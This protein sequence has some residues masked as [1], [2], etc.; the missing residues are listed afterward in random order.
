[1]TFLTKLIDEFGGSEKQRRSRPTK[2]VRSTCLTFEYRRTE[3]TDFFLLSLFFVICVQ[4]HG[5]FENYHG[6]DGGVMEY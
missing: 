4:T 6:F 3:E 2:Q 5:N 1:M